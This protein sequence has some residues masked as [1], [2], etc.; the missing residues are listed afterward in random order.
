MNS[1][2]ESGLS[3]VECV[4]SPPN[5]RIWDNPSDYVSC[6]LVAS[7]QR[8]IMSGESNKVWINSRLLCWC[9]DLDF[10][11]ICNRLQRND[12]GWLSIGWSSCRTFIVRIYVLD[13]DISTSLTPVGLARYL[14][15]TADPHSES[16]SCQLGSLRQR[17]E[18]VFGIPSF[19]GSTFLEFIA[20][21]RREHFLSCADIVEL[22]G[23]CYDW[24]ALGNFWQWL[25]TG[26]S[27]RWRIF[28]FDLWKAFAIFC[29][30]FMC[31]STYGENLNLFFCSFRIT[32]VNK[33]FYLGFFDSNL[34]RICTSISPHRIRGEVTK[35]LREYV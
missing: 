3:M 34:F 28:L 30:F 14:S 23:L 7:F 11:G 16:L 32:D 5:S 20:F 4:I 24:V 1:G 21:A 12:L 17:E 10:I 25:V 6:Y 22:R 13:Q 18:I 31:N 27:Y 19:L 26:L 9:S 29:I 2:Y 33:G 8:N 15:G 35:W